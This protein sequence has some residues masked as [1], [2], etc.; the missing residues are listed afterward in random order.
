MMYLLTSGWS[1]NHTSL[2]MIPEQCAMSWEKHLAAPGPA[3]LCHHGMHQL[4]CVDCRRSNR[5]KNEHSTF[6]AAYH[7][8]GRAARLVAEVM[9]HG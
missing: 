1:L 4:C 6:S 9:L 2:A 3:R 5:G 8:R 7:V